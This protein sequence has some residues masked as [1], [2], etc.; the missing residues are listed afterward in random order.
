MHPV[1]CLKYFL[2]ISQFDGMGLGHGVVWKIKPEISSPKRSFPVGAGT[3]C[4]VSCV[5][6]SLTDSQLVWSSLKRIISAPVTLV[7]FSLPLWCKENVAQSDFWPSFSAPFHGDFFCLTMLW[8]ISWDYLQVFYGLVHFM[9]LMV[10]FDSCEW[11]WTGKRWLFCP[12]P[13]LCS[14]E[15]VPYLKWY[16]MNLLHVTIR[17]KKSIGMGITVYFLITDFRFIAPWLL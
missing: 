13:F 8:W 7:R 5:T 6:Y 16:N 14:T 2:L 11:D 10:I 12:K 1:V 17:P 15:M 4:C 3:W 9:I